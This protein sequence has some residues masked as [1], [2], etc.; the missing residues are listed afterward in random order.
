MDT[1][2]IVLENELRASNQWLE[3]IVDGISKEVDNSGEIPDSE[4]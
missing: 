4:M 3:E 2:P 1:G